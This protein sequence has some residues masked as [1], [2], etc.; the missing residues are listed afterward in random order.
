[1][2]LEIITPDKK[3]FSGDVQSVHVPGSGGQLQVLENHAPLISNIS[4]GEIRIKT[5][6]GDKSFA[7]NSGVI[8]VLKNNLVILAET[9]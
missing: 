4:K 3:I 2:F 8:E 1:M 9:A 5:A 7:I 6:E